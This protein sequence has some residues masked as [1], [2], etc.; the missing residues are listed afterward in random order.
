MTGA[1]MLIAH[2]VLLAARAQGHFLLPDF[3]RL[4]ALS[5]FIQFSIHSAFAA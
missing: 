4:N 2:R 1:F 3:E 5:Q